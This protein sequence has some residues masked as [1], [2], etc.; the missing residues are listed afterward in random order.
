MSQAFGLIDRMDPTCE[1]SC[2]NSPFVIVDHFIGGSYSYGDDPGLWDVS[3]AI[4]SPGRYAIRLEADGVTSPILFFQ[5]RA[6]AAKLVLL[7]Q[8]KARLHGNAS[9]PGDL[10]D[11]QPG[12]LLVT[13]V[14]NS[15]IFFRTCDQRYATRSSLVCN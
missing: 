2:T 7:Q 9:N 3:I 10:F 12:N 5:A 1:R 11:V 6:K 8:P 13:N 15:N 4:R 14:H